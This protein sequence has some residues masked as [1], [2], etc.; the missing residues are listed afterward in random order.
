MIKK[1]ILSVIIVLMTFYPSLHAQVGDSGSSSSGY[2]APDVTPVNPQTAS[3]GRYGNVPI[4]A[5]TGKMSFSVPIYNIA[6]DGGAMPVS[7]EYSYGGLIL[8]GAPSLWGLGW[9]LNAYGSITKEVRG[10]PDGHPDGYYGANNRR[11]TILE[12]FFANWD[13]PTTASLGDMGIH[14]FIDI[15]DGK[16]DSE[17]DKYSV[18]V[19]GMQFSF[20]LRYEGNTVVPYYLSQHNYTVDVTMSSTEYFSVASFVVTSDKGV[21]YYFDSDNTESV[22]TEPVGLTKYTEDK[23]TSWVLSSVVYPNGE[24]IE[25]VY[26]EEFYDLWS[27]A[28]WGT[29]LIT[30]FEEIPPGQIESFVTGYGERTNK[31]VMRRMNLS[32]INFP[33]GSLDFGMT[34]VDGR[35]LYNSITLKNLQNTIIDQYDISYLGTRDG[36]VHI[37]K[38]NELLYG[39]EYHGVHTPETLPGF[40]QSADDRPLDQDSW[41]YFNNAN[42]EYAVNLEQGGFIADKS[43]KFSSTRLGAM[44]RILYPTGGYSIIEYEQNQIT[45]DYNEAV[46]NNLQPFNRQLLVQLNPSVDNQERE[47]TFEYTFTA[48]TQ[49]FISHKLEGDA[50]GN[51]LGATIEKVGGGCDL[52]SCYTGGFDTA[53]YY[54]EQAPSMRQVLSAGCPFYPLPVLCPTLVTSIGP[55]DTPSGYGYKEE[56]SAGRVVISPGTYRFTIT[57]RP[58]GAGTNPLF[59]TGSMHGEIRIGFYEPTTDQN[60]EIPLYAN[61]NIGGIRVGKVKHY[62]DGALSNQ[63]IYD[64]NNDQG[65]STGRINHIPQETFDQYLTRLNYN[66]GNY[67]QHQ[68]VHDLK[69]F[70]FLNEANGVP[71]YYS[72]VRTYAKQAEIL[73]PVSGDEALSV[74]DIPLDTNP[75]D[76]RIITVSGPIPNAVV[77]VDGVFGRYID[78]YPQ[79]YTVQEF[80]IPQDYNQYVYPGIP[81]QE[82]LTKAMPK[83]SETVGYKAASFDYELVSSN[84]TQYEFLKKPS[85]NREYFNLGFSNYDNDTDHPWS[86]KIAIKLNRVLDYAVHDY[87]DQYPSDEDEIQALKD[88]HNVYPYKEVPL[89]RRPVET[90]SYSQGITTTQTTEYDSY[91]QVK[92]QTTTTSEAETTTQEL[93]YPYSSEVA[94]ESQYQSMVSSNI[95]TTPVLTKT[96]QDGAVLATQK[97][98]FVGVQNGFKPRA[99]HSAKGN[100]AL[101]E[102]ISFES[103]S[104]IGNTQEVRQSN[105]SYTSYIWGYS[106]KYVVAK[107]ENLRYQ[108]AISGI[109]SIILNNPSSDAELRLELNKIRDNHPNALVTTYTYKPLV[110]ITSV[111]DPRGYMMFYQYDTQNRL[112]YVKDEEGK[113]YSKNEYH[114]S[115]SN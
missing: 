58:N 71:V 98:N 103:Y 29:T 95:I 10:L 69:A 8:E 106:G 13:D 61:V 15:L 31:T 86:F 9:N 21:K 56:N 89:S 36:L 74:S 4:N 62:T 51:F 11:T 77:N 81:R 102:R 110:G 7:L 18:N 111:T 37:Q 96:S 78:V 63:T 64:Y 94:S 34:T 28:A 114:Y 1:T 113:V 90:V 19:G 22:Y 43:P 66:G 49:A 27:Y 52:Y 40:Y 112:K 59:L 46:A 73:Q 88:L 25:Y 3:L 54:Y 67:F 108:N 80:T 2:E 97:I 105:G 42:N 32:R 72:R 107:V 76:S 60:D 104:S 16:Y 82:D 5:A 109:S 99:I 41:K 85:S 47:V 57:T 6:V 100:D 68:R 93:F 12:P 84:Q 48:P 45:D 50:F 33:E 75:N 35:K 24:Q 14:D 70:S 17:V 23:N 83:E 30:N 101:E 79:G 39:F 26:D 65:Y 92:K 55:D 44:R 53:G 87:D 20:K 91:I 38:N 115:T